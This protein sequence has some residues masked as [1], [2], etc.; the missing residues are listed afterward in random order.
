[1]HE[2]TFRKC[3]I[4]VV[5]FPGCCVLGSLFNGMWTLIMSRWGWML[6]AAPPGGLLIPLDRLRFGNFVV[7]GLELLTRLQLRTGNHDGLEEDTQGGGGGGEQ[8]QIKYLLNIAFNNISS[9][10]EKKLSSRAK[11]GVKI[12]FHCAKTPESQLKNINIIAV[13]IYPAL[14]SCCCCLSRWTVFCIFPPVY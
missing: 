8:S 4:V 13:K 10:S 6:S 5:I 11:K 1:M 14:P 3:I 12:C 9:S 2:T 7:E